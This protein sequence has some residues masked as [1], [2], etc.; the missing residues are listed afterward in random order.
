MSTWERIRP[1][2]DMFM[3][4]VIFI[5]S[6][7]GLLAIYSSTG[8]LAYK[9]NG[10]NVEIYLLQQA[11]LLGAGFF[12]MFFITKFV[13]LMRLVN[14][15]YFSLNFLFSYSKINAIQYLM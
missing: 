4:G 9:K 10:G 12:V 11:A 15:Y 6:I 8:A 3:W 5:L 2:G 13:F 14:Y 7:W 1:R